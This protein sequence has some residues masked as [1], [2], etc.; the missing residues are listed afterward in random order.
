M[1]SVLLPAGSPETCHP[2]TSTRSLESFPVANMLLRDFLAS[3]LETQGLEV[4]QAPH[5]GPLSLY[6][7]ADTWLSDGSIRQLFQTRSPSVIKDTNGHPLAWV[8]KSTSPPED[9]IS[10]ELD[11]NSFRIL[12]PWD[13]LRVNE[14]AVEQT[15]GNGLLGNAPPGTEIDG[16]LR[17]G[18]GTRLLP[19]VYVDGDVI[20]GEHCT[21]GPNCYLRGRTSIGDGCKI[22]QAVEIKNSVILAGTTI[23][24]LSYCGDS[25]VC[26]NVNFGAGTITANFR[27]D[28]QNHQSMVQGRLTDTG[29]RKFG[30]VVGDGV[31]TGIH[32]SIYPGRK[33]WPQAST[34]PGEIV[35]YDVQTTDGDPSQYP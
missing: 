34:R 18:H 25:I 33:L 1:I 2:I 23:G 20:I 8:G 22:G 30:S 9:A 29:R 3:R 7:V 13:L 4:G 5:P 11:G 14:M 6:L 27:H 17:V 21:I 10:L 15:L 26:E 12:F 24:H 31:H 32:T 16:R 35:R 28:G 19:G